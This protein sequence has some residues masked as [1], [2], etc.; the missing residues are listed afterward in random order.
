MS[1]P[2]DRTGW[3]KPRA[4]RITG[5]E[6]DRI[7]AAA[8]ARPDELEAIAEEFGLGLITIRNIAAKGR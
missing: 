1:F 5:A 6:Y 8:A 7:R 4:K 2:K 3:T